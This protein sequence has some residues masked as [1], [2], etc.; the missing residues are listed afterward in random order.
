MKKLLAGLLSMV[1][2]LTMVFS[3]PVSATEPTYRIK[4]VYS[5]KYLT[6]YL[7]DGYFRLDDYNATNYVGDQSNMINQLWEIVECPNGSFKIVVANNDIGK[8][9]YEICHGSTYLIL[10]QPNYPYT[11]NWNIQSGIIN[12]WRD[13]EYQIMY[14]DYEVFFGAYYGGYGNKNQWEFVPA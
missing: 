6:Y 9:G 11:N 2:L 1:V 13:T 8:E 7:S 12:D 14:G 4:N 5:G 10:E 3:Q